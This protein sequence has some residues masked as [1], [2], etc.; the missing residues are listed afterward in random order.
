MADDLNV[1]PAVVAG[2]PHTITA[3]FWFVWAAHRRAAET[4]A[5]HQLQQRSRR[6]RG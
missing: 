4:E 5:Q 1:H 6:R 2:V 3:H